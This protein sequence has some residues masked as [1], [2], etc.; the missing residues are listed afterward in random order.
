M[1]DTTITGC[2]GRRVWDSRGRPTV[3]VEIV[4]A[5]GARG[6]APAPAGASTGSGEAVDRR[7]GGTRF[8]G[9]DVR[10]ALAAVEREIAPALL[11][12]DAFDQEAIDRTLVALDGT[13]DKYRLG[14]NALVATSMA[15]AH[16]AAAAA[17]LPLWRHLRGTDE[18]VLP[19]PQIQILGGGAH[20]GRR[21]DI[22][23]FMVVAVGAGSYAEALD[24]TAEI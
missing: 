20:A 22:Q 16:A 23:D 8:G 6:R 24:W 11:G 17:G 18:A 4:L 1:S 10:G 7:D 3:E 19:L 9:L 13:P 14:G 5:G 12:R 21:L 15:V 2:H